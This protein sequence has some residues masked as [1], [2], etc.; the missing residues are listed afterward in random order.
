MENERKYAL[1]T[2][3]TPNYL[4]LT[5]LM[6]YSF[7]WNNKWFN[8]DINI[9]CPMGDKDTLETKSEMSGFYDKVNFIGVDLGD[10]AKVF[11]N[12]APNALTLM[13]YLKFEVFNGG[14]YDRRLYLDSDVIVDGDVKELFEGTLANMDYNVLACRDFHISES[15]CLENKSE[16]SYF[17]AGMMSIP[18]KFCD[19]EFY[20]Q[21]KTFAETFTSESFHNRFSH[22]G[23]YVDQ[24]V[25]NEFLTPDFLPNK[26]YNAS[27]DFLVQADIDKVKIY[28]YY[29]VYKP[30]TNIHVYH[31]GF[32]A[33]YRY[34]FL[35]LNKIDIK[36]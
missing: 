7:L 19:G 2:I 14:D 28:H 6:I 24:D 16:V 27:T 15:S 32:A 34:Y 23:Q 31:P 4:F 21:C 12:K 20:Q 11:D 3:S 22:K 13:S 33:F 36:K 10:Y 17:N 29:G 30:Y 35:H 8:G 1:Y 9:I 5:R 18:R 26:V 25:F